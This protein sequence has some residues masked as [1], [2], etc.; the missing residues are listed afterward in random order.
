[1]PGAPFDVA[2][3]ARDFGQKATK[4]ERHGEGAAS[5]PVSLVML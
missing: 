5:W 2:Y 3:H 4:A 1:M